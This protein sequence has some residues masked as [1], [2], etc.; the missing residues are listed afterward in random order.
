MYSIVKLLRESGAPRRPEAITNDPG[1][2]GELR[3]S[4]QGSVST[5]LLYDPDD[6]FMRPI[7]PRLEHAQLI[8]MRVDLMRFHGIER[9]K[10]GV[11]FEQEWSVQIV[12]YDAPTPTH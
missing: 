8:A 2:P 11:G 4:A 7:I 5:A 6:E 12:G 1:H 10:D 9:T 3:V